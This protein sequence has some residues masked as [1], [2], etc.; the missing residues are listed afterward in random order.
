MSALHDGGKNESDGNQDEPDRAEIGSKTPPRTRWH[1]RVPVRLRHHWK[2]VAVVATG[3]LVLVLVF[4]EVRIRPYVTSDLTSAEEITENIE[5]EGE[6]FDDGEHT[7]EV[8]FNEDEYADMM[9]TFREEGEKEYIRADITI[10]GTVVNDVALRLKGNSTLSSLGGSGAMPELPGMEE[11]QG[12]PG[13]EEGR[14]GGLPA[15]PGMGDAEAGDE[16]AGPGQG[17]GQGEGGPIMTTLSEDEPENLPWLISFDE[18]F[19]GRAYQGR[20]EITLRPAANGSDTALNEALALELTA[21]DEQ[22]T[23]EYTFTSFGVN[24]GEAV[25]RLLLDSPDAAWAESLGEGV[26]YKGR[27]GG[28]LD[29]LGG[30]PTDYEEA[31]N[32]INGEGAYDL[33][34]VMN[35]LEFLDRADDEEFVR[36]LDEYVDV[37]SFARYLALQNLMSNMDG[38]DGPGNNYYLWYDLVEE[39]FTVLSWDLNMSF[40]DMSAMMPGGLEGEDSDG[41]D[42]SAESEGGRMPEGMSEGMPP[43]PE[44]M[45]GGEDGPMPE[46]M[47]EMG[48]GS[49]VLKERFLD[50]D[51]FRELYEQ[52][53]V[54]L[55]E[56]LVADGTA[57]RLLQEIATRAEA[58]GDEG[59]RVT[60]ETLAEQVEEIGAEPA[61]EVD[62][63]GAGGG[64]DRGRRE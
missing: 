45:P 31:F 60:S 33:Q 11:G 6:L 7:I 5:G 25:P 63:F 46:G 24:D 12:F 18:Y 62:M 14:S 27:A 50:D 8:S 49:G 64:P 15:P 42:G 57:T 43:M 35:L 13:M 47:E 41:E 34:P 44:G 16:D 2:A 58:A 40:T 59:A 23:Q 3:L 19:T 17:F 32:Q 48:R 39:R 30:D 55:Y 37:E 61:E 38:M 22:I 54:D 29:Y 1:H 53:Y 51:G 10:D 21:A 28:S 4:G 56:N 9:R 20:T 26:L 52:A 36:E